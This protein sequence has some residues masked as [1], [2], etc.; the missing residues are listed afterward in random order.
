MIEDMFTDWKKA[1]RQAVEN[2][3]REL[4]DEGASD[5]RTRAMHREVMSA[6]GAR[7]KLDGEI[8]RARREAA[9]EREQEQVCR[10]REQMARGIGDA[11][12]VRLAVEF[13]VRHAER[14]T[15]LERKVDVLVA[16]HGLLVRDLESMEKVL[17]EQPEA[18]RVSNP[19]S[20]RE[21]LQE[22]ERE[23]RDFGQLERE[24]R[25]RAAVQRLEELKR[26]MK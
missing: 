21:I 17:A 14:A 13:A 4:S 5:T 2:F 22:R 8:R 10:R 25:E 26:R 16:E 3:R 6:R 11:E 18:P 9:D 12:T 1:W 20:M 23:N 24:A 15:V 7:E 19:E